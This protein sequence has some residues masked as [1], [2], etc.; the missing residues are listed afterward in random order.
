MGFNFQNLRDTLNSEVK[1]AGGLRLERP[2]QQ[3]P[4]IVVAAPSQYSFQNLRDVLNSEVK[5]AGGIRLERPVNNDE[6]FKDA[7]E[8]LG[9]GDSSGLAILA[10]LGIEYNEYKSK[11]PKFTYIT[12]KYE[13]EEYSFKLPNSTPKPSGQKKPPKPG[14]Q[15]PPFYSNNYVVEKVL[16][17][18]MSTNFGKRSEVNTDENG[19][20]VVVDYLNDKKIKE[21][22][23]NPEGKLL[24]VTEFDSNEKISNIKEFDD[25]GEL[26]SESVYNEKGQ[27]IKAT[28]YNNGTITNIREIEYNEGGSISVITNKNRE[29]IVKTREYPNFEGTG[30]LLV[31]SYDSEGNKIKELLYAQPLIRV[32]RETEFDT[33][34]RKVKETIYNDDDS[35]SVSSFCNGILAYMTEY[36]SYEQLVHVTN[37]YEN[38]NKSAEILYDN[39]SM[40]E[41]YK[42]NAEG[43][44]VEEYK[45]GLEGTVTHIAYNNGKIVSEETKGDNYTI[46]REYDAEENLVK[47]T[48]IEDILVTVSE[49]ENNKKVVETVTDKSG[50]IFSKIEYDEDENVIRKTEYN[51]YGGKIVTEGN[52]CSYY[53][54][55][56][57][58]F[59]KTETYEN[60]TSR[61]TLYNDGLKSSEVVR[62]KS[63]N[64][65]S[66]I[67]YDEN[68]NKIS[69][70]IVNQ[71]GTRTEITYNPDN[72]K[73]VVTYDAE[74]NKTSEVNYDS[75]GNRFVNTKSGG[76][77][78]T[79]KD[80]DGN[81]IETTYD[82]NGNV[83]SVKTH[84]AD[85][86][87]TIVE[88]NVET[89]CDANGNVISTTT[90][91]A[92]GTKTVVEGNKETI[93]DKDGNKLE[94]TV[95][96][97]D[98][99]GNT[100]TQHSIYADNKLIL[101]TDSYI[102][103]NGNPREDVY[104]YDSE[105][106]VAFIT[107][108]ELSADKVYT[109]ETKYDGAWHA[110]IQKVYKDGV[111]Y[112]TLEYTY[113]YTSDNTYTRVI[114]YTEGWGKGRKVTEYYENNKKTQVVT[115]YEDSYKSAD[116]ETV[117]Y[118]AEGHVASKIILIGNVETEYDKDGKVV[119]TTTYNA[120]GTKTVTIGNV[121]TVYDAD[122]KEDSVTIRNAD[123]SKTV[124]K[125]NKETVYDKDG[126]VVSTTTHNA[127]G[128]TTVVKGNIETLYDSNGKTIS[129]TT[130][131]ADGT[132]TVVKGNEE[133]L[134]GKD[135]KLISRTETIYENG[136]KSEVNVY[137]KDDNLISKTTFR[138]ENGKNYATTVD[139]DGNKIEETVSYKDDKG[140][141]RTE[142]IVYSSNG[143]L[144]SKT[145]NSIDGN[146]NLREDYYEYNAEGKLVSILVKN[147]SA[148][149]VYSYETKYNESWKVL[150]Q[151]IYKDG[152]Y[153]RTAEYSYETTGDNTYTRVINY[154][155]GDIK[156]R[157][158]T[159]Y[160]ENGKITKS[161]TEY[162]ESNNKGDKYTV[163]YDKNGKKTKAF[164]YTAKTGAVR[165]DLFDENANKLLSARDRLPSDLKISKSSC[166]VTVTLNAQQVYDALTSKFNSTVVSV[167]LG[168]FKWT[169]RQLVEDVG[170]KLAAEFMAM[171]QPGYNGT[172]RGASKIGD[173]TTNS[174][175]K[176]LAGY[177]TDKLSSQ[178]VGP[179]GYDLDKIKGYYF[180]SNS[181]VA[182]KIA[183]N[184]D[185]KN[186][187]NKYKEKLRAG[188]TATGEGDALAL[189][190]TKG[191][192]QDLYY[193]FHNVNVVKSWVDSNGKL[194][195]IIADTYDF[196][197]S[198]T[199][200][201]NK[202]GAAAM[203]DGKLVPYYTLVEVVV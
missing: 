7:L 23:T 55:D 183:S 124:V 56:G 101:K 16:D 30:N 91:N 36:N 99:K 189:E 15:Q 52:V 137:D 186:F 178:I 159:E 41:M 62:D 70:Y 45:I 167:A 106:K 58:I 176:D 11:S 57:V 133:F 80:S 155:G 51:R 175:T 129:T 202:C 24:S 116:K 165:T 163:Y 44:K 161:V 12:F 110:I 112:Y 18:G 10:E 168:L 67:K 22:V 66:E 6:K 118:D 157:K 187:V 150:E 166:G 26:V 154:T 171:A 40:R 177:L 79:T 4:G 27:V 72:S 197:K 188:Y 87:S 111:H 17:N 185:F 142:H 130:I 127:D 200:I 73:V 102:D 13:G 144:V 21:T 193:T 141:P 117:N 84:N 132:K 152:V 170:G 71:D 115:E 83:V 97:K 47:E 96:F 104:E 85:G 69:E 28:S 78:V 59:K 60:G 139:K 64:I 196:N 32:L 184:S 120:N 63:G 77:I 164:Y 145:I 147:M 68:E 113:E 88:G 5:F 94:E 20:K 14:E 136:V 43:K 182:K 131:N 121:D 90:H 93:Y 180:N 181:D 148:D 158:V 65:I 201:L 109:K 151:K 143:K 3:A 81:D 194:H 190:F 53:G 179:Y 38:G 2:Q 25:K 114:E 42:Y 174:K 61:E 75:D 33:Q 31:E 86:T 172:P 39:G 156:G 35:K 125:G 49:Y 146:G 8:K 107:V 108:K 169:G 29:G 149:K 54:L 74:G 128:T 123:G 195:L 198:A 192:G 203:E 126:K 92:D 76:R 9:Q 48:R 50:N 122:G 1:F 19:N 46:K 98:D 34:G 119:S 95:S 105:G 135:G 162:A 100:R 89:H 199:D 173:Y 82:K 160:Y 140:N 191:N 103:G 138:T 134:Y 37:Y 153:L